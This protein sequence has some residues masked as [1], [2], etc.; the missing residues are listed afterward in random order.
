MIMTRCHRALYIFIALLLPAAAMHAQTWSPSVSD[1]VAGADTTRGDADPY[2]DQDNKADR[3][4]VSAFNAR[5]GEA[6]KLTDDQAERLVRLLHDVRQ[7]PWNTSRDSGF[8]D[9]APLQPGL[10]RRREEQWR[11]LTFLEAELRIAEERADLLL[12]RVPRFLTAPQVRAYAEL[13]A[14]RLNGRRAA[15]EAV[16]RSLGILESMAVPG[17]SLDDARTL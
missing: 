10:G 15:I 6:D 5:L 4:E 11:H 3:R 16:R 9:R 1:S 8:I 2:H 12:G 13:E 7:V 14:A 17:P